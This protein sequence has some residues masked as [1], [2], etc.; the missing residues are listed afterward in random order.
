MTDPRLLRQRRAAAE[1][2]EGASSDAI[3]AAIEQSIR[4]DAFRGDVLDFGCGVGQMARRLRAGG[5]FSSVTGIDLLL[6]GGD[7]DGSVRWVVADLNEVL[8]LRRERFDLVV[9]AEVLEHL[10]NP[11]AMARELFRVLRPGG[12]LILTT[13][14]NESFRALLSLLVRG[15]FVAFG[16]S[17]YPAHITAVVRRDLVRLL[18]EAGFSSIKVSFVTS[19]GIPKVPH[20]T[21]QRISFGLLS[22]LR[23][24][25]NLLILASKGR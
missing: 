22:G 12:L 15:H 24:S 1:A 13:P 18:S 16:E 5:G 25:D 3:Y 7:G 19:G 9:A 14:N 2:S 11:R 6:P 4:A 20:L 17:S 21:W 8:P 10:E 23:F